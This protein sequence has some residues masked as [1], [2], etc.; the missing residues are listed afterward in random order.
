MTSKLVITAASTY[1][2]P[3]IPSCFTPEDRQPAAQQ[4]CDASPQN[5]GHLRRTNLSGPRHAHDTC[6]SSKRAKRRP[7]TVHT[8][9]IHIRRSLCCKPEDRDN[10]FDYQGPLLPTRHPAN[11]PV[12][13]PGILLAGDRYRTKPSGQ[14][15]MGGNST[16]C[17]GTERTLPGQIARQT[18]RKSCGLP[19]TAETPGRDQAGAVMPAL[20]AATTSRS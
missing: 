1:T 6:I 4:T 12:S 18:D 11:G 10:P 13:T 5:D 2:V 17:P 16:I 7:A 3:F 9:G 14:T 8:R 20:P 19:H 15:G